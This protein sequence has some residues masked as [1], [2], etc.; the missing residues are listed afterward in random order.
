VAILIHGCQDIRQLPQL[1]DV[2]DNAQNAV[3][4]FVKIC[5]ARTP[6]E[7]HSAYACEASGDKEA[8]SN[9]ESNPLKYAMRGTAL[10]H[11]RAAKRNVGSCSSRT[12]L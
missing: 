2:N 6:R 10:G 1:V 7:H 11:S 4:V 3:S 9:F 5:P 12:L 8:R